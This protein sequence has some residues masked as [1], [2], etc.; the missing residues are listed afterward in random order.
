MERKLVSSSAIAAI[1]HDPA[2]NTL[3]V[4]MANGK[5]YQYS[6]VSAEQHAELLA[7]KSVG[8]HWAK[9]IKPHHGC[10]AL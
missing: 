5:V 4:E 1:G 7:A 2:T 3:E 6:N 10:T 9:N 8:A